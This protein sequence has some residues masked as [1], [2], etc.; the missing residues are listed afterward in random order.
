M[1]QIA[2]KPYLRTIS[3]A[4]CPGT[5]PIEDTIVALMNA[6]DCANLQPL[7]LNSCSKSPGVRNMSTSATQQPVTSTSIVEQ[8]S[9]KII[10]TTPPT[11]FR[12]C[13][14]TYTILLCSS[15]PAMCCAD[16]RRRRS[17]ATKQP[18]DMVT[19]GRNTG[20]EQITLCKEGGLSWVK[21]ILV[22]ANTPVLIQ[23][24]A[25]NSAPAIP[26]DTPLSVNV[27]LTS[28]C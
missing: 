18:K 2:A 21:N 17:E 9:H 20:V 6:Q 8:R 4:T 19:A 24:S 23:A 11:A 7:G 13:C 1:L 14:R 26:V 15:S 28:A 25:Y 5:D 10:T 22:P 3:V 27:Q 12:K 16:D